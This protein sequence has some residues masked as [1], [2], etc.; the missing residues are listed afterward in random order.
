MSA[1]TDLCRGLECR[2]EDSVDPHRW[3]VHD[4]CDDL[5]IGKIGHVWRGSKGV[6][7]VRAAGISP[8][9]GKDGDAFDFDSIGCR[10]DIVRRM[11]CEFTISRSGGSGPITNALDC[12]ILS[13]QSSQQRSQSVGISV[14]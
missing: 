12:D 6:R 13:R 5:A 9:P 14:D 1:L 4:A 7:M 11:S 3:S 2:S 10:I 8:S